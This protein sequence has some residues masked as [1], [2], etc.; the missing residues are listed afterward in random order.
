M[1]LL[2]TTVKSFITLTDHDRITYKNPRPKSPYN[3]TD[4]YKLFALITDRSSL[5]H[6]V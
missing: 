1:A 4:N 3:L 5:L 2:L 6:L